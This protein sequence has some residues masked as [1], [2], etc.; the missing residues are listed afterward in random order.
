MISVIIPAHNEELV[1]AR[2]L[3]AIVT[4]AT[5]NELEVI[6][7]CNGCTDRTAEIAREFGPP[8][9]V[10]DVPVASKIAALNA[11]DQLATGF[12]RLYVDADVVLGLDSI[13]KIA[14]ALDRGNVLMATPEL[15]MDLSRSTWPIR[16]FYRVWTALPHNRTH[17]AVG[18][19][20][21]A[22]SEAGRA[23]WG[24]FPDVIADDGFVRFCFARHER[25]TIVGAIS[26]VDPPRTLAGLIRIKTRSR[27]GQFQL[28]R[29]QP[30]RNF[31]D[32]RSVICV[33]GS[34]LIRPWLL[35]ELI[36]YVS[37]TMWVR[38]RAAGRDRSTVPHEWA[39]DDSRAPFRDPNKEHK[40]AVRSEPSML[41]VVLCLPG[42]HYLA[43]RLGPPAIR[44]RAFDAALTVKGWTPQAAPPD[45]VNHVAHFAKRGDIL[46]LGCGTGALAA[47]M[48]ADSFRRFLGVDISKRA[49]QIARNRRLPNV[50]FVVADLHRYLPDGTFNVILFEESIY[51]VC[52]A[53][54]LR[55]VD[56]MCRHLVNGGV[57]IFSIA[58]A[59][60]FR[61]LLSGLRSKLT[62]LFESSGP[63]GRVVMVAE[64]Q[65][66]ACPAGRFDSS[67]RFSI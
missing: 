28:R 4:G 5:P 58:N 3:R 42:V 47:S 8:V 19:G 24:R 51:Y 33:L 22:L 49:I 36:T 41:D 64:R 55:V 62:V 35:P 63:S 27:A 48:P 67:N 13:R 18:T 61:A 2:G 26:H 60:R 25:A 17:G 23:R 15:C 7:A 9:R 16:A 52:S 57:F 32:L 14:D 12:P 20:V 31:S 38:L 44:S 37:I 46:S 30:E 40:N 21:Y 11:A 10:I 1:I 50:E 65:S 66:N 29:I 53:T 45:L 43:T 34:L 54:D 59:N 39:R 6:V 56:E